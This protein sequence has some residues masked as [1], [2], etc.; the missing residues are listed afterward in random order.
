MKLPILLLFTFL[1]LPQVCA[2]N[3]NN[4]W[5]FGM[6][7][8]ISFGQSPPEFISG[9]RI[10]TYEGSASASDRITGELLF[11]TNGEKV[12]DARH[13]VMPNGN[14]LLGHISSTTSAVI[15]PRPGSK[16]Q[17][18]IVCIDALENSPSR[19]GITYN[20]VD[21]TLNKGLG[22]VVSGQKNNFLLASKYEMLE[23]VPAADGQ[24][25]WLITRSEPEGF[26]AFQVTSS[27]ILPDPVYSPLGTCN[28]TGHMKIN[29]QFNQLAL[30]TK[31]QIGSGVR[32]QLVD[33]NNA[34]GEFSNVR[35]FGYGSVNGGFVNVYGLEFSPDGRFLYVSDFGK[36]V[37]FDISLSTITQI[38]QSGIQV[39]PP[40]SYFIAGSLQLGPDGRIYGNGRELFAINYPEFSGTACGFTERAIYPFPLTQGIGLPKW[41]YY[42]DD[43]PGF[44]YFKVSGKQDF[45][46]GAITMSFSLWNNDV[47]SGISWDFG[48]PSSG[49]LNFS[50]EKNPIHVYNNPG[51]YKVKAV[52]SS[53]RGT[54]T[55][56]QI[57]NLSQC[58]NTG[59]GCKISIPNA[60][61]PNGDG[62]NDGFVPL[63]NCHLKEYQ[64]QIFN[65]LGQ[66]V[67]SSSSP[68]MIW[69]DREEEL[70]AGGTNFFYCL[71]YQF[72]DGEKNKSRGF[73]TILR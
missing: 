30:G 42:C 52:V 2:Q 53:V 23:V 64:L 70:P 49:S 6:G 14:G 51:I 26:Y 1:F 66:L 38:R 22:D 47:V 13:E 25:L 15:I 5:H 31:S 58:L 45:C 28:E 67:F 37:Q 46:P 20:L 19:L 72:E 63:I 35:I 50:G 3:Q 7:A 4:Q 32:I 41:V 48:D 43:Y 54:L 12:W 8:S 71:T 69:P 56:E 61:T 36:V 68:A 21:M 11:Y 44:S 16:N 65:R 59:G 40:I 18:F 17:Y 27:G 39:S 55:L 60:I 34:T 62:R 57:I 29:R 73:F 33:F 9:S 24:S 10:Y